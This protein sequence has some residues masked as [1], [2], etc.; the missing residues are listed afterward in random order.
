MSVIVRTEVERRLPPGASPVA[1]WGLLSRVRRDCPEHGGECPCV[2][3]HDE[4][5]LVF[6]CDREGHAFSTR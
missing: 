2:A 6:W 3:R 4:T 5:G 1:D